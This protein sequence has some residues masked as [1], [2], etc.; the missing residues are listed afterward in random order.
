LGGA[1]V[2]SVMSGQQSPGQPQG[3]GA[4]KPNSGPGL[5][6]MAMSATKAMATFVGSGMK[7]TPTEIQA[8]RSQTCA[9]CEHHTGM[10]CKI[11]GCFTHVKVKMAHEDCPIGKWPG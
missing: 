6:R 2:A 5:L 7:T 11:C 8:K 1:I 10:R 4:A 9:S 3:P